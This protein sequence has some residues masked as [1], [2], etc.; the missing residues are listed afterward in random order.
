MKEILSV[1]E[2]AQEKCRKI[3]LDV[4]QTGGLTRD[5]YVR[6]LSMQSHLT[7]GVQKHFFRIAGHPDLGKKPAL[8][9]FLVRFAHEEEFHFQL[10]E[11]DLRRMG[12]EPLGVMLDVKLWWAFFDSII[13]E[14]PF[15]RLGATCILENITAGSRDEL[16]RV[17]GSAS[18]LNKS[19]TMFIEIHQHEGLPHGDQILEALEQADL[20]EWQLA[21]LKEG[22]RMGSVLFLRLLDWALLQSDEDVREKLCA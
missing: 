10:A 2:R 12:A 18:F 13:D 7:R 4:E 14:K 5:R 20:N 21:D 22:A 3:I 19:N 11:Q 8:R 1:I 17:L 15:M 6:L 9:K 16:R